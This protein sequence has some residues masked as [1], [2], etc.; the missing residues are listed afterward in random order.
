MKFVFPVNCV[1][2]TCA[3]KCLKTLLC[4][5]VNGLH[6]Y[7][8]SV[9]WVASNPK[10]NYYVCFLGLQAQVFRNRFPSA[11]ARQYIAEFNLDTP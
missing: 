3:V 1:E 11:M 2:F 8:I 7:N 9:L 4:H 10:E 5:I 6:D